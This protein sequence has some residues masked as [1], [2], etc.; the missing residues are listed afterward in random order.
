MHKSRDV[1]MCVYIIYV[2]MHVHMYG[3]MNLHVC[4]QTWMSIY[5]YVSKYICREIYMIMYLYVHAYLYV[6]MYVCRQTCMNVHVYIHVYGHTNLNLYY[7]WMVV[8]RHVSMYT[9]MQG[10]GKN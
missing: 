7:R 5:V 8:G 10:C 6:C 2:C 1:S 4:R 9:W 3:G